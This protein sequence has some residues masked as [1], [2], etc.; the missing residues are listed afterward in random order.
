MRTLASG[1]WV[2]L[3]LGGLLLIV[4][5]GVLSWWQWQRAQRDEQ[6]RPVQPWTE[7]FAVGTPP[8]TD[9]YGARVSIT[10]TYDPTH[11]LL[12]KHGN[13]FW[14]ITPLRTTGGPAV[15]VARADVTSADAP[16][17][18]DVTPGTVTVVGYAQPFE[19]DPGTP[20]TLPAGQSDRLTES[21]LGAP[22]DLVDGWVALET[23]T[24]SAAV[25]APVVP[26]AIGGSASSGLRLQNL[27]Y[28]VQWL[29]FAGFVVF[30]WVRL[31]RDDL[32]ATAA[33]AP[34]A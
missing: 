24:P 26:P 12:V 21:A 11:Q 15:A 17:V 8:S 25:A 2:A 27:S 18:A 28:A 1:K 19:G 16:A 10:G 14:V 4:A 32:R 31:L 34:P 9:Q 30:F 22:Y 5:F 6:V 7:V 33:E 13:G 23:Q 29:I 3:T 20:S